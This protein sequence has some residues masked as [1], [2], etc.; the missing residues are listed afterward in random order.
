MDREALAG[1]AAGLRGGVIAAGDEGYEQARQVWNGTIDKHPALIVKCQGAADVIDAVRFAKQHGLGVSVRGGGHH[2]AGGALL[3]GGLVIDLS[4]MRS[5]RV[6]AAAN[7]VRAEGGALISDVDR[8][9]GAFGLCVPLGVVPD[10]GIAGL[11]LAGGLGLLRRKSG[12]TSDNLISADVVTAGGSLVRASAEENPD[13]FWA[14]RGGGWDM[15]VVTSFEFR[16]RPISPEIFLVFTAYP[17]EEGRTVLRNFRE[18]MA[19]APDEMSPLAIVWTFPEEPYPK[20]LWGRQFVAVVGIYDGPADEGERAYQPLRQLAT[21]LMDASER[22]TYLAV[23]HLFAEDYPSGRRYYWK[24]SY[25]PKLGDDAIDTLLDFGRR[26]PSP[27]SSVDVWPLG[28][29]LD[30]VDPQQTAFG[31]RGAGYLIGI[32]A[33]WEDAAADAANVAWARET[34]AALEPHSTGGSYL[35]FEDVRDHAVFARSHGA[36]FDRLAQIKRKYDPDNLFRSRRLA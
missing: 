10:T 11:T 20:E 28:G 5:V 36:N 9:A 24:S 32:E 22:T 30:R 33:N 3:D 18:F 23:Q 15:G 1:L 13:L 14:L 25:L 12:M 34:T 29:A 8:E 7:T 17:I 26:R 4:P 27:L 6:D 31:Q 16:A 19:G 2:V 35:N 21:P